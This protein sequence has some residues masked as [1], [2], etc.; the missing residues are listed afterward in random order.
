LYFCNPINQKVSL[1]ITGI[2][3][4]KIRDAKKQVEDNSLHKYFSFHNYST[5]EENIIQFG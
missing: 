2:R 4:A 5:K 1:R 3:R